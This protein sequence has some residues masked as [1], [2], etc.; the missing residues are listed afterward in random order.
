VEPVQLASELFFTRP[1][2]VREHQARRSE[3]LYNLMLAV[4]K[5]TV[6]R[7]LGPDHRENKHRNAFS[8]KRGALVSQL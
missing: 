2:E 7:K 6:H 1:S 8:Y 4:P 3:G 5:P